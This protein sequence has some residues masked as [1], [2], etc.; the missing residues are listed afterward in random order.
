MYA[1]VMMTDSVRCWMLRLECG[2][3]MEWCD[4]RHSIAP[5]IMYGD[6]LRKTPSFLMS[7]IAPPLAIAH[8]AP[9]SLLLAPFH[10]SPYP[11]VDMPVTGGFCVG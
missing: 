8:I 6:R 9:H 2:G 11:T 10:P 5:L 7:L 4:D 3:G 1:N